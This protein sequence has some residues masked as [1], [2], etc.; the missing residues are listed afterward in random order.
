MTITRNA[1]TSSNI[2]TIGHDSDTNTLHVAFKNG[3][4]YEYEGVKPEQFD[5]LMASE[6]KGKHLN[7][8]IIGQHKAKRSE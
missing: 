1:V 6:S 5:A 3:F 4:N 7:K 8:H 2:H